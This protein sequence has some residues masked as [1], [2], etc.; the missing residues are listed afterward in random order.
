[1]EAVAEVEEDETDDASSNYQ[2]HKVIKVDPVI[3][4]LIILEMCGVVE[5]FG[6][7]VFP[8]LCAI[9]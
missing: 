6:Q 5:S 2:L 9:T 3:K 1:M 4:S 7:Y 8:A